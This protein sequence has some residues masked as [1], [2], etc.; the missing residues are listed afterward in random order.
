MKKRGKFVMIDGLDGVCKGA[1]VDAIVDY[2]KFNKVRIEVFDI[3]EWWG[4]DL[5]NIPLHDYNPR[6]RD[7]DGCNVLVSSEPTYAGIGR[8]IR[9]EYTK[10]NGRKYNPRLIASAYALDRYEL[11]T[12]TIIPARTKGIDVIQSG[13]VVT[14]IVYQM[15]DIANRGGSKDSLNKILNLPGNKLAMSS[16][17]A[18]TLLLILTDSCIRS[19]AKIPRDKIKADNAISEAEDFQRSIKLH[20]ESKCLRK[21]FEDRGT[22]VKYVDA[23]ISLDHTKAEAVRVWKE[24]LGT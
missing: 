17:N 1:A 9:T 20:Y 13:G 16:D 11:Y 6:L 19:L 7:F 21:L 12:T 15:L 23:G 2:E 24:H 22:E 10:K 8:R 4:T 5:R 3:N 14:N 18:P